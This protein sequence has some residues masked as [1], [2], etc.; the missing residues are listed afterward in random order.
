M[1][2]FLRI[3]RR[4]NVGS[5][6][7]FNRYHLVSQ[8]SEFPE[9][10]FLFV[11]V[12]GDLVH[13]S[14]SCEAWVDRGFT[15]GTSYKRWTAVNISRLLRRSYLPEE[16]RLHILVTP[17]PFLLSDASTGYPLAILSGICRLINKW[18]PNKRTHVAS[19]RVAVLSS[20][21]HGFRMKRHAFV[22]KNKVP[23]PKFERGYV[24]GVNSWVSE[25]KSSYNII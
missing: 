13:G 2:L 6:S 25:N 12:Y 19:G 9:R 16:I 24:F 22:K 7:V 14:R 11:Y 21:R 10:Y 4:T 15:S 1:A 18:S 5:D 20:H 3:A 23:P 17:R 8:R